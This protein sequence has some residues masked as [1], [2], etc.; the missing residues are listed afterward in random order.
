MKTEFPSR[1]F[2]RAA[3]F[4]A[5]ALLA[6]SAVAQDAAG[7]GT[8]KL[9]LKLSSVETAATRHAKTWNPPSKPSVLAE[10]PYS[11]AQIMQATPE[12]A[13]RMREK[14]EAVESAQRLANAAIALE[15]WKA[16]DDHMK[17]VQSQLE[18]NAYGRQIILALDKFA[19]EAGEWLDPECIEFFHRMDMDEG[20]QESA[21]QSFSDPGVAAAPCFV[22]LVFDDPREESQTVALNSV[23]DI[24][25]TKYTQVVTYEVQDLQG[26]IL[27]AKNVKA[28]RTVRA[29]NS[30]DRGGTSGNALV[31]TLHEALALVAKDINE[32]FVAKV[33]F[34]L[35]GPKG[36]DD[37]DQDLGF[38]VVDGESH[39]PGDEF[40]V[41][42]GS[43]VVD[44]EMLGYKRT[45][46]KTLKIAGSKAYKIPMKKF[47]GE[48]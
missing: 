19:G 10:K 27:A 14:N 25:Q 3:Q 21:L 48:E 6:A 45:G 17:G 28:E 5:A 18:G 33:S 23:Q 31:E 24:K 13:E 15:N 34:T 38:V 8:R 4:A 43:H 42:K 26:K 12:E 7:D 30:V 22:K 20:Q 16:A 2:F 46:P 44:V 9:V 36:D 29:S 47:A 1:G 35:V 37:F 32:R 11:E 40:S 41:L 39:S